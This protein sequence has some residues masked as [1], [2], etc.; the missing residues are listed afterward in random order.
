M[1]RDRWHAD[2][3][4]WSI[5]AYEMY[6]HKQQEKLLGA[7]VQLCM[8]RQMAAPWESNNVTRRKGG[9]AARRKGAALRQTQKENNTEGIY[10]I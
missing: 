8:A 3:Q 4:G 7:V 6:Q 5:C 10:S 1:L 2:E 9:R